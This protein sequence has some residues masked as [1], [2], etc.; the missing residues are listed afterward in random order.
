MNNNTN[1]T[2]TTG[3]CDMVC[4]FGGERWLIDF[5]TS[6][7]RTTTTYNGWTNWD[8][9]NTYNWIT[10]DEVMYRRATRSTD[11]N[12]LYETMENYIVR[13][14]DGIDID[15]V[16]WVELYDAFNEGV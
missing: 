5:K 6:N 15:N 8:T 2:T 12:H 4:E 16:N 9:W 1:T 7:H 11:A 14:N 13:V 3:T 10:D